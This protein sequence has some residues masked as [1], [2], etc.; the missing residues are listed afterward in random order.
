L[1]KM[2][3][4]TNISGKQATREQVLAVCRDFVSQPRLSK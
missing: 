1:L 3:H 4:P 2:S